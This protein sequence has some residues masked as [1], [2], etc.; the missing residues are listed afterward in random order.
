M[1]NQERYSFASI[2]EKIHPKTENYLNTK[3]YHLND[4]EQ[5]DY[6][7][8]DE[9]LDFIKKNNFFKSN[10]TGEWEWLQ[11]NKQSKYIK[12]LEDQSRNELLI[13]Y[14]NMFRNDVSYGYLSPS[15]LDIASDN[16]FFKVVS[17]TLCNID[18][19]TEFT[20]LKDI[21]HLSTPKIFGAPYGAQIKENF[22]LP[23]SPR[24][25]YYFFRIKNILK[26]KES[27]S[28]LEIGGGYGGLANITKKYSSKT[29]TYFDIDLLPGLL[30]TYY[31]L[32]KN[33]HQVNLI[34]S[35]LEYKKGQINLFP[36]Q[37]INEKDFSKID[38]DLVFNSRSLCEM[39]E[40]TV[41]EY[42]NCI[43]NIDPDWIFHENS[44]FLLFP[45]SERHI[46]VLG[47]EF[48]IDKQRFHLESINI[49]PFTGGRGRYREFLYSKKNK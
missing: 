27:Q 12:A 22:I 18:T 33:N 26:A 35:I 25:Y 46:E 6:E 40:T 28:I 38:V 1:Q 10:G 47:S 39:S 7:I 19:T 30:A 11:Q 32:R 3:N 9:I 31:F 45:N 5:K 34:N 49:T 21:N 17:D 13:L 8:I 37:L 23:D 44:N 24:H 4:P 36:Y 2:E 43:K 20:D 48:P 15:F 41:K 42:F 16:D 14:L 29:I